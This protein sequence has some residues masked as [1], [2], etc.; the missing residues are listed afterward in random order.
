MQIHVNSYPTLIGLPEYASSLNLL[1]NPQEKDVIF[2]KN[3]NTSTLM[4]MFGF[5]NNSLKLPH[6]IVVSEFSH[7]P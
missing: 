7:D 1:G 2:D 6:D 4:G 3:I 5:E